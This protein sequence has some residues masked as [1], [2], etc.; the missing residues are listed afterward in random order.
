MPFWAMSWS[1][2]QEP[3]PKTLR[4]PPFFFAGPGVTS[5]W[6]PAYGGPEAVGEVALPQARSYAVAMP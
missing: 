6:Q 4:H 2:V 1:M 3:W 5:K